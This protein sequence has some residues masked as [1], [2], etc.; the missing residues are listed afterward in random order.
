MRMSSYVSGTVLVCVDHL[1]VCAVTCS[2]VSGDGT[3]LLIIVL[4]KVMKSNNDVLVIMAMMCVCVCVCV[5]V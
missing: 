1:V 5:C 3:N 2:V 4:A